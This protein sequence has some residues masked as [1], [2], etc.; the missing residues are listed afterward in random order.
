MKVRDVNLEVDGVVVA[1]RLNDV[2]VEDQIL[3]VD[4]LACSRL[5]VV[6]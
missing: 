3:S 6:L 1:G 2:G 5:E 4:P